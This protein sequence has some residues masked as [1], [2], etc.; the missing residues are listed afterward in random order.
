MAEHRRVVNQT[1]LMHPMPWRYISLQA[2]P[3]VP[4]TQMV[5]IDGANQQ[6]QL[7]E[8]LDFCVAIS[9]VIAPAK[10]E[11]EQRSDPQPA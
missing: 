2:N 3:A 10:Q 9:H 6:V 1:M 7:F 11:S 4:E 8:M 5:M